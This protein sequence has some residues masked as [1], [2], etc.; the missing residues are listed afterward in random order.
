[1]SGGGMFFPGGPGECR[2]RVSVQTPGSDLECCPGPV[3]GREKRKV[4]RWAFHSHW[5]EVHGT[6]G[7]LR[8]PSMG[9]FPVREVSVTTRVGEAEPFGST[10]ASAGSR[11]ASPRPLPGEASGLLSVDGRLGARGGPAR[12][13]TSVPNSRK[14]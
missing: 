6:T 11:R 9:R 14:D 8:P 5:A 7:V 4:K 12:R 10:P 13:R 1:V 3:L 2:E